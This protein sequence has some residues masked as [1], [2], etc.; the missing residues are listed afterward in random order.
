MQLHVVAVLSFGTDAKDD[1]VSIASF[2]LGRTFAVDEDQIRIGGQRAQS[3]IR[4]DRFDV[5]ELRVLG[6]GI[7][8]ALREP[9]IVGEEE[10]V[11]WIQ[12]NLR[13]IRAA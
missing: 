13:G 9:R 3:G 7:R 6:E 8:E 4:A 11:K 10:D 5:G 1:R 12:A 2:F